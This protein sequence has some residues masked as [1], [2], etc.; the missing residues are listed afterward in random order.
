MMV[1]GVP[2]VEQEVKSLS[3]DALVL[4]AGSPPG[5][6]APAGLAPLSVIALS[7]YHLAYTIVK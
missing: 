1:Q 2:A 7:V 6:A 5:R 4:R 3:P